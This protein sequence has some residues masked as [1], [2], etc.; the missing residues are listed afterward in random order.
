MILGIFLKLYHLHYLVN[1]L[2]LSYEWDSKI[3]KTSQLTF[4][5]NNLLDNE[6]VSNAWVY[7]FISDGYDPRE[8]DHYVNTDSE[9][10]TKNSLLSLNFNII[11]FPLMINILKLSLMSLF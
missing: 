8:Y 11:I 1:N 3:F 9:R 5:V 6:F 7:R 4:Q 2:R 10:T